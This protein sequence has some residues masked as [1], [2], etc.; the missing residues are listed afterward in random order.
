MD[1]REGG[2]GGREGELIRPHCL[3][4]I[5]ILTHKYIHTLPPHPPSL[6][7]SSPF[8][9]RTMPAVGSCSSNSGATT[10]TNSWYKEECLHR[11]RRPSHPPT[12]P[13]SHPSHLSIA[14]ALV[15]VLLLVLLLALLPVP[16][17]LAFAPSSTT[18]S[19]P[20]TYA[21][22]ALLCASRGGGSAIAATAG[23]AGP[24]AAQS[25]MSSLWGGREGR[26]GRWSGPGVGHVF[27][28]L[29]SSSSSCVGAVRF[30]S[31]LPPSLPPSFPHCSHGRR[32]RRRRRLRRKRRRQRRRCLRARRSRL[33]TRSRRRGQRGRR[34]PVVG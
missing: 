29:A 4:I 5:T 28:Y 30:L 31:L 15:V 11:Q 9:P 25:R 23:V 21:A 7:P 2:E 16:V 27:E 33:R 14:L 6:P 1:G 10:T 20:P 26:G 19:R 24:G 3:F 8:P 32:R 18:P 34:H 22:R 13:P 17:P 12:L